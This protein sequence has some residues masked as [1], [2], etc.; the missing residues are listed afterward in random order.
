MK[1][2]ICKFFLFF[3]LHAQSTR[4]VFSLTRQWCS[5]WPYRNEGST[6]KELPRASWRP[7]GS[8][9]EI[10]KDVLVDWWI[11]WLVDELVCWL[12]NLLVKAVFYE[13][14][15]LVFLRRDW[16]SGQ[17]KCLLHFME[18]RKTFVWLEKI[19]SWENLSPKIFS[20]RVLCL[21]DGHIFFAKTRTHT[22]T[23][24]VDCC[25]STQI[26]IYSGMLL[27]LKQRLDW[28]QHGR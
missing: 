13:S 17:K 3:I 16:E 14:L 4:Y 27:L 10:L 23:F 22:H 1:V 21:G 12:I 5:R 2:L 20:A 8:F 9:F 18:V 28:G 6:W 25:Y 7:P 19:F 11:G 15:E 26:V 24:L